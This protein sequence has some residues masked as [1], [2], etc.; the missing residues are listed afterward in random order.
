MRSRL[1]HN[2]DTFTELAVRSAIE[3][4]VAVHAFRAGRLLLKLP[5]AVKVV[6]V[7]GGGYRARAESPA[8][9]LTPVS[10]AG[11]DVNEQM[12]GGQDE[13]VFA[14]LPVLRH[15]ISR[16]DAVVAF[17]ADLR[18][19]FRAFCAAQGLPTRG[20]NPHL[21]PQSVHIIEACGT[22]ARAQPSLRPALSLPAETPVLLLV[23][24][25]RPVK[26][27]LYLE[28]VVARLRRE[29]LLSTLALVIVGPPLDPTTTAEVGAA[30]GR[31]QGVHYH[32]PVPR[33][34]LLGWMREADVL[35][36]S[37]DSEGQSNALLEG[38][39]VGVP[40]LARAVGGNM[41]LI[42]HGTDGWVY[43]D[44]EGAE[45]GL[46]AL[47]L[48]SHG[49]EPTGC[50]GCRYRT[51]TGEELGGAA[52]EGAASHDGAA[53]EADAWHALVKHVMAGTS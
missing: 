12:R 38:A 51:R 6:L 18:D 34:V 22:G 16:A 23:A 49:G 41:D 53:A 8:V 45:A 42:T 2:V 13:V 10:C 31:G 52:R 46:R 3:L 37:S 36:N 21:I 25:L 50:G 24:G 29:P 11:T 48:T 28:Q 5:D 9:W 35:V 32:A 20:D 15:A 26:R 39:W 19:G 47:L 4:V 14:K 33:D 27:P 7:L 30:C 17:T 44:E 43:E 1:Q 40:R